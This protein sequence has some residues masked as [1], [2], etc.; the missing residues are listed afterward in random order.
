MR[1]SSSAFRYALA[2]LV[3]FAALFLRGLLTPLLGNHNNYHTV[4]L[5][6]VFPAWHC[7][8]GPSIL[9]TLLGTVGVWYFF[10]PPSHSWTIQDRTDVYGLLGFLVFSGAIIALGESNRRGLAARSK[11]EDSA[12]EKE[13]S[14]RLLQLQDE[15]KRHIARE[16]HDGVGQLLAAMSM[17]ACKLEQERSKL[18]PE[19][20]RCM[21]ENARLIQQASADIRMLSY[22]FHPH[23][24]RP[25]G[26][27]F[28]A[29]VV[30]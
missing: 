17:N 13:F 30:H 6:V 7:G 24:T 9:T 1:N 26:P 23:F 15:E 25:S 18:G 12:K 19:A 29:Q 22:L 20:A 2:A 4:W 5:A 21:E 28:H 10:L 11:A 14:A 16:L 8:L 3:A 27:P